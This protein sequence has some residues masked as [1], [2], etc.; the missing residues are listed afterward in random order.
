MRQTPRTKDQCGASQ[1]MTYKHNEGAVGDGVGSVIE[2]EVDMLDRPS[3][4]GHVELN[5]LLR[6]C[7]Q[8]RHWALLCHHTVFSGESVI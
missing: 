6:M 5:L 4:Q 1:Y 7:Q 2:L 8:S 3:H